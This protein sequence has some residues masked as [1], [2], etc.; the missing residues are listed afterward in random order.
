MSGGSLAMKPSL[1]KEQ[2]GG[3][4]ELAGGGLLVGFLRMDEAV[5]SARWPVWQE[6]GDIG[7]KIGG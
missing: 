6:I 3:G 4:C 5:L 7:L 2:T 1:G